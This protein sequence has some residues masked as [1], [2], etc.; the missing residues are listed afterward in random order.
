MAKIIPGIGSSVTP[1][2][3]R[4]GQRLEALLEDDY[5]C[6]CNVPV[7]RRYQRP[8]FIVLHPRRGLLVLEVKDWKLQTIQSITRNSVTLLTQR[9]LVHEGN[10]IE[11]ARQY[12]IGIKELLERDRQLQA[13]AGHPYQGKLAFPYGFGV[14]LTEITRKQFDSVDLGEAIPGHLVICKDEMTESVD[15]EA[16]QKRLWDMFA[17]RFDCLL[18]MPQIDRVRWHL[19]PEIRISQKGLFDTPSESADVPS[20]DALMRVMDLQQEQLA[21]SL[22]EGHRVIHGAAGS[23]KTL[24]LGYRCQRL[25]ETLSKPILVLCFNVA[26]ASKLEH[27]IAERG[28]SDRVTVRHFHGW[29][30]DQLKLYHVKK[31]ADGPDYF[32]R[33][34]SAVIDAVERGHIPRA[35]YGAVLID[36][37]HDF[38]PEWLR[39]IVQM[40]DPETNSLLLLYDDAQSIYSKRRTRKFSLKSV[41]IQAQGRTTILR[42]NYRNTNEILDCAFRV[43]DG[44]IRPEDAG[45]DGIPV[46]K[47]EMAGRHGPR[48]KLIRARSIPDEA[49]EIAEHLARFKSEGRPWR[50]MAVLYH[51]NFVGDEIVAAFQRANIPFERLEKGDS[52]KYRVAEES[53]K[54]MTIYQSKGLEFPVVAV[55]GVGHMAHRPELEE[56][57]ARLLYVAM[58]RAT[59]ALI[60][61]ASKNS[62]F[63]RKWA[64]WEEAAKH[65][66]ESRAPMSTQN[67]IF[68]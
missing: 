40:V 56:E 37:G 35:Q 12:A 30:S 16:F 11:Q 42:V 24:I 50:D 66:G 4:F 25:A 55:A 17:V 26:L 19:F 61:T 67:R 22:G 48:P 52:R 8:D 13:P 51:A 2:E 60:L 46:I 41:G 14:V 1:G 21:R 10:P 34:V 28:L 64:E 49:R 15:P 54:L 6:W 3:R 59:E 5:L 29:C 65:C 63:V 57:D 23:G 58:T 62:V 43:A 44:V 39:L 36:E 27:M 20:S 9:G 38:A 7:G 32:D 47:P 33:L 53:V 68:G 31:P 18:T 45:D